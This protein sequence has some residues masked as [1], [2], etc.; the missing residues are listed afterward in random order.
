LVISVQVIGTPEVVMFAVTP[1][2]DAEVV[3]TLL[4]QHLN[5][6]LPPQ[7]HLKNKNVTIVYIQPLINN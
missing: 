7:F 2:T 3:H 5:V 1:V 6:Q 4:Q